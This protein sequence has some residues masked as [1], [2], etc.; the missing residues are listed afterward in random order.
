MRDAESQEEQGASVR[1]PPPLVFFGMTLLGAALHLCL[2]PLPL[3][4]ENIVRGLV[5]GICGL[6]G[7]GLMGGAVGLFK[8]TKQEPE[9][10]KP[11][12]EIIAFAIDTTASGRNEMG[13]P[14]S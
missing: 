6:V 3:P 8:R 4:I 12:P 5:A 7:I 11:S 9:P 13:I 1:V 2:K 14:T 10:W